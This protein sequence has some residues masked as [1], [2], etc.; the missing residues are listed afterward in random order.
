M[1]C[2]SLLHLKQVEFLFKAV[3]LLWGLLPVS[4]RPSTCYTF[5]NLQFSEI[6][7]SISEII[8]F[9]ELKTVRSNLE[10]IPLFG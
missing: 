6:M 4:S 9:L 8:T 7:P 5:I 2:E 10:N 1:F 3:P